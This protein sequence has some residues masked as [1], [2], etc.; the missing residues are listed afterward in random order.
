MLRAGDETSAVILNPEPDPREPGHFLLK[1]ADGSPLRGVLSLRE[2]AYNIML[3]PGS[4]IIIEADEAQVLK[5]SRSNDRVIFTL[6]GNDRAGFY[7]EKIFYQR[8]R[9]TALYGGDIA[10]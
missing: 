9:Q 7:I 6:P 1:S 5:D 3:P 10:P 2:H 4:Y 8:T